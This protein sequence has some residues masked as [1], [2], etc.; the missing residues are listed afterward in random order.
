MLRKN[1][2]I[3]ALVLIHSG[4]HLLH[5]LQFLVLVQVLQ[6]LFPYST[7]LGKPLLLRLIFRRI[8]HLGNAVGDLLT[9]INAEVDLVEKILLQ[10]IY[11]AIS[12]GCN[13]M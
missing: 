1:G 6:R 8:E 4:K 5:F 9:L 2:L 11:C 13:I 12:K 10:M 7:H 3:A